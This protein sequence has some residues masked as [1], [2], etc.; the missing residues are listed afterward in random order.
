MAMADRASD[1]FFSC[2]TR[3]GVIFRMPFWR[4]DGER[5]KREK[6][7][8]DQGQKGSG[9]V[10][11]AEPHPLGFFTAIITTTS[12]FEQLQSSHTLYS[13]NIPKKLLIRHK[14]TRFLTIRPR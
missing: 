11:R 8:A 5:G 2:S 4:S 3:N 14:Q 9:P 13:W 6:D 10:T 1:V 12:T 7:E